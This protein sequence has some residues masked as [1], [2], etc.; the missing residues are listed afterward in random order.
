MR[1][2]SQSN[3]AWG[4]GPTELM[5]MLCFHDRTLHT[6]F[7]PAHPFSDPGSTGERCNVMGGSLSYALL[8]SLFSSFPGKHGIVCVTPLHT[9]VS[10]TNTQ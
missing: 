8:F 6:T 5:Q 3:P 9:F 2:V 7:S 4:T 1:P 10:I